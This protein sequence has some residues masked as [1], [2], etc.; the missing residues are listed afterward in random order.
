MEGIIIDKNYGK[1]KEANPMLTIAANCKRIRFNADL[2][3]AMGL[4]SEYKVCVYNL[5][6]KYYLLR[7]KEESYFNLAAEG[8]KK[9]GRPMFCINSASLADFL[10]K[11]I[12]YER[13]KGKNIYLKVKKTGSEYR[14]ETLFEID[15]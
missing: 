6:G 11:S 4:S 2:V 13:M 7:G 1:L 10:I 9:Q 12:K 15:Y 5:L 3:E 14:G 8:R